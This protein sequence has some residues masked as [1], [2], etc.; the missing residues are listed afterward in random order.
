MTCPFCNIDESKRLIETPLLIGF[1]DRYPVN[2]GHLLLVP[3]RHVESWFDAT[4][5]EQSALMAA[6]GDAVTRI[7]THLGRK[8]N[9]Y[10]IGF[11]VGEAAGQTVMHLHLHV[12]PR[13]HGDV[14][15]FPTS[16]RWSPVPVYVALA[17]DILVALGLFINL[18]VFKENTYGGATVE[19]MAGQKVISSGPYALIRH[20]MYAGVLV[21]I[22]GIPLALDAWW[23]LAII[24]LAAPGLVWRILDEEKLLRKDL[25]GYMEYTQKVRYR[26]I[27]Y[28]W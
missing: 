9:G 24:V 27:P 8:P 4:G 26:L 14:D 2:P 5:E 17:G 3:R 16:F 28:I 6:V 25:P 12:I 18:V 15:A 7:E 21:M 11:N 13:F 23:S 22:A 20:P 1:F 10:N 19:T